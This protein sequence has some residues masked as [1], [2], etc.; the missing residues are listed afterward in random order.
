MKFVLANWLQRQTPLF[1]LINIG[2]QHSFR[3]RY[4]Q[5]FSILFFFLFE[6]P[7]KLNP[8]KCVLIIQ[9]EM[10]LQQ[11]NGIQKSVIIT[12][13]RSFYG[14]LILFH[15]LANENGF[16]SFFR[17]VMTHKTDILNGIRLPNVFHRF[18]LIDK[19]IKR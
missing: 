10:K 17:V 13:D 9:P 15:V 8:N 2:F 5:M 18:K 7:F 4:I 19:W 3:L 11:L 12:V 14:I 6:K 16:G 1:K